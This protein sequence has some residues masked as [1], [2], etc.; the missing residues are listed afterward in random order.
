[1]G[2]P[3]SSF[4]EQVCFGEF[5]QSSPCK[6]GSLPCLHCGRCDCWHIHTPLGRQRCHLAAG[7]APRHRSGRL[8]CRSGQPVSVQ[9]SMQYKGALPAYARSPP[10]ASSLPCHH[11]SLCPLLP[12]LTSNSVCPATAASASPPAATT[13]WRPP[14]APCSTSSPAAPPWTSTC[15]RSAARWPTCSQTWRSAPDAACW[16]RRAPPSPGR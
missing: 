6:V 3:K 10:S 15:T 4:K 9:G 11:P 14:T 2:K 16:R 7:G 5:S 12:A 13:T 1:M 8:P